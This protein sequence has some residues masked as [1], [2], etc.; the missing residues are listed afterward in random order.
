MKLCDLQFVIRDLK[1]EMPHHTSRNASIPYKVSKPLP[2]NFMEES[3][4]INNKFL[5][6]HLSEIDE[7]IHC[8]LLSRQFQSDFIHYQRKYYFESGILSHDGFF[9]GTHQPFYK[10]GLDNVGF[11]G[12]LGRIGGPDLQDVAGTGTSA[13]AANDLL[14]ASKMELGT[15][16]DLYDQIAISYGTS[17]GNTRVGSYDDSSAPV[18]LEVDSGSFAHPGTSF[19]FNS[20]TEWALTTAQQWCAVIVENNGQ[21]KFETSGPANSRYHVAGHPPS[22]ALADPYPGSPILTD[23]TVR[24]TL[25]HS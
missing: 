21:V 15:I 13:S 9:R 16:S 6:K 14:M 25:G 8:G 22:S 19:N 24:C 23:D 1:K 11:I 2:K 17:D 12:S 18:N 20:V 7:S 10:L 4:K 3:A 5:N